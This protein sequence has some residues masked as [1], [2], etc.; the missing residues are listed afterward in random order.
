MVSV[1]N[2]EM[3]MSGPFF[4]CIPSPLSYSVVVINFDSLKVTF[5][6]GSALEVVVYRAMEYTLSWPGTLM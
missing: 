1:A 5:I 4:P 6:S 3:G 2:R